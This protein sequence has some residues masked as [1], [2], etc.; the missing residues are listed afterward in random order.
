MGDSPEFYEILQSFDDAYI[1]W[2]VA[3]DTVGDEAVISDYDAL[4][5]I[6]RHKLVHAAI[7]GQTDGDTYFLYKSTRTLRVDDKIRFRQRPNV[8][9]M[10]TG[11]TSRFPKQFPIWYGYIRSTYYL[12]ST[13]RHISDGY[14]A[15]PATLDAPSDDIF[16]TSTQIGAT[17]VTGYGY[18]A[19]AYV[20]DGYQVGPMT[21]IGNS[22]TK[23]LYN[24]K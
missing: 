24:I 18:F 23:M 7:T 1:G 19:C 2:T 17:G 16:T 22:F 6:N 8:C 10:N 4:A 12:G 21:S 13:S 11:S 9:V 14:Y 5:G 20:Y 15:E 3:N